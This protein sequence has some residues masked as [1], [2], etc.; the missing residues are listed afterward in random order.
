MILEALAITL[1]V[2]V[3][4]S[5]CAPCEIPVQATGTPAVLCMD[6]SWAFME[7]FKKRVIP[8]EGKFAADPRYP[9]PN[10]GWDARGD[11]GQAYGPLQFRVDVHGPRMRAMGLDPNNEAHRWWFSEKVLYAEQGLGPWSGAREEK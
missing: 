11:N 9:D 4:G 7:T 5:P 10:V 3:I 8:F 2:R 1:C 6:V